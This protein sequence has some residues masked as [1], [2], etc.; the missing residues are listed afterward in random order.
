[1]SA[2]DRLG[3]WGGGAMQNKVV[4][5]HSSTLATCLS[6]TPRELAAAKRKVFLVR[7]TWRIRANTSFGREVR[8][9]R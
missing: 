9:V 5:L 6:Q 2:Q 4:T 7:R 1:M 3:G 8:N